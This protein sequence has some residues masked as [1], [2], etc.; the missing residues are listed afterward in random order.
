MLHINNQ[1]MR[2]DLLYLKAHVD[3]V[4][5]LVL[6]PVLEHVISHLVVYLS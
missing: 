2:R 4:L 6:L 3:E 5:R 1:I